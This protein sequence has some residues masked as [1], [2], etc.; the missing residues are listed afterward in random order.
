MRKRN[1]R[2]KA[3]YAEL[4]DDPSALFGPGTKT[5]LFPNGEPVIWI[6]AADG[7]RGA[8]ITAGQGPAGFMVTVEPIGPAADVFADSDAETVRSVSRR[9]EVLQYHDDAWS[10]AFRLW[11]MGSGAYP[12]EKSTEVPA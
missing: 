8:R 6:K 10:Q 12:G 11:T 3:A 9:V 7:I 2:T 5:I 4:H 1:H